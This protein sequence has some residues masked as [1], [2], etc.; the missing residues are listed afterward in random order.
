MS[1]L[2]AMVLLVWIY[3]MSQRTMKKKHVQLS[4]RNLANYLKLNNRNYILPRKYTNRR[5]L[6]NFLNEKQHG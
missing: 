4:L 5:I 2:E 3:L 1:C 6:L